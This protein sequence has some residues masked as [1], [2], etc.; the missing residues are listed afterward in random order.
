MGVNKH[1]LIIRRNLPVKFI[2]FQALVKG[3]RADFL[4]Q[5]LLQWGYVL[6]EGMRLPSE[7]GEIIPYLVTE[8]RGK[9]LE[10]EIALAI[11]KLDPSPRDLQKV[12]LERILTPHGFT[13]TWE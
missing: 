8:H 2:K 4:G 5:I 12:G 11:L 9:F 6:T 3:D 1:F 10:T 13:I 7:L